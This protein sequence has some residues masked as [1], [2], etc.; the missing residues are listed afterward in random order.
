MPS[1]LMN[2]QSLVDR[3]GDAL[4]C[5]LL[6]ETKPRMGTY[7][8]LADAIQH[9]GH[10]AVIVHPEGI[11]LAD[12]E[13]AGFGSLRFC[14]LRFSEI[15]RLKGVD[16]FFS[17]EVACDV[18]PP[19]AATIGII[20]S[21]PDS[22]LQRD[23]LASN[24]AHF[25]ENYPSIIRTFDYLVVA[26]CQSDEEWT[27]EN[28]G[29]VQGVYPAPFLHGRRRYLDIVPGG[30]P[31]LD[32]S[33]R[34]L[35]SSS[36]PRNIV[37]SPTS[38]ASAVGRVQY[39]GEAVLS[40]LLRA[41]PEMKIIF[42]PYPSR[43]NIEHGRD[44]AARF[45]AFPNFAF[46]ETATGIAYQKDCAVAVTDSSSSALTFSLA[47]GRP[48]VLVSLEDDGKAA[49]RETPFGFRATGLE[50][51]IEGVVRGIRDAAQWAVTI[52][53]EAGK[54]IYH[55]GSAAA[56]LASH[57]NRFANR[58]S[59]PDWLSV[60]RRPWIGTGSDGEVARHLDYLRAWSQRAGPRAASAHEEIE[61]YF[62]DN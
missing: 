62:S 12:D 54:N 31:K 18:A 53:K 2:L 36:P 30:Y 59:H 10:E 32:Y 48:L 21:I 50:A 29:L 4:F 38:Q 35:A 56:Y 16:L 37:Y 20:H 7:I 47:T 43:T 13:L 61:R 34:I 45:A 3:K 52:G 55:P 33:R 25:I 58:S 6:A 57:L 39:D 26:V 41:F 14:S 42:R 17:P 28:Y 23:R 49:L 24:A 22:G 11:K 51:M 19:G 5:V 40:T 46:D 44:L 27:T 60:E 8:A 1:E 9:A 15:K